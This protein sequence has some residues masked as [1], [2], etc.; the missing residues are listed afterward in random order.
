MVNLGIYI[1]QIYWTIHGSYGIG[2]HNGKTHRFLLMFAKDVG[3][4]SAMD[5]FSQVSRFLWSCEIGVGAALS[6]E[7]F[8]TSWD[9]SYW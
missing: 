5:L 1:Y 8:E 3:C 7:T 4:L 9:S 6:C 2:R